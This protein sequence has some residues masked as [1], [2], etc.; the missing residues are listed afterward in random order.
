M[1]EII[2]KYILKS[3]IDKNSVIFLYSGNLI[4]EELKLSEIIGKVKKDK[5]KILV[6]SLDN[7]NNNNSIIKSNYI[8]WPKC[9][10]N[11]KYKLEDY[12]ISLYE[13]K[14]GHRIDNILLDEFDKTQY[15]YIE[16]NICKEKNKNNTYNNEFYICLTCAINLCL[17]CKSSHDK[18]HN[19][20]NYEQKNYICEK[21]NENYIK[22]CDECKMN[23]CIMCGKEHKNHK[24]ILFKDIIPDNE[25]LKE[26]MKELRKIIDIFNNNIEE[27]INKL[28]KVKENIEIYYNIN[29]NIIN[30]YKK[31]KL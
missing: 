30:N 21:H 5:I 29:N 12:K 26:Y 25:K 2:N 13:Y 17:F 18:L 7:I 10:E 24:N 6:N 4:D 3:S 11:I 1:E 9:K 27:I 31:S 14:N 16:C 15:I 8:I 19:I 23:I 28:K 20:I 22:Y